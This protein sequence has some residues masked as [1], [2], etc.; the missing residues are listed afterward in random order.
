MLEPQ[1]ETGFATCAEVANL[2]ANGDKAFG[3][4]LGCCL[5]SVSKYSCSL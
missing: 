1:T 4:L 3:L 5:S 2:A